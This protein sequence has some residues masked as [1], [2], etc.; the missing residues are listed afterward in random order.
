MCR[1]C[2]STNN[3]NSNGYI[4]NYNFKV[5]A[6]VGGLGLTVLGVVDY[7]TSEHSK[8]CLPNTD[9]IDKTRKSNL[10]NLGKCLGGMVYSVTWPA[11]YF[12]K[13]AYK[14]LTQPKKCCEH[15]E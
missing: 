5:V 12:I 6:L 2:I 7:L 1:N 11:G 9:Q 8:N 3:N 10:G 13:N 14:S 15:C 4:N